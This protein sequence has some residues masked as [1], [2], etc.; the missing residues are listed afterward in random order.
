MRVLVTGASGFIGK[1]LCWHLQAK[2]VEL[3]AVSRSGEPVAGVE[4]HIAVDLS[5]NSLNAENL[6][7]VD[8]VYHLAGI[9]HQS[10]S[11]VAYQRLNCDAVLTLAKQAEQAG[12]KL[13]VFVSSVRAMGR[14]PAGLA[15]TE[16]QCSEPQDPYGLSKWHAEQALRERFAGSDMAVVILRPALVCAPE[17]GGNLAKLRAAVQRG[18][19]RPPDVGSR[20]V[21]ARSDL[22]ELL[23]RV[24]EQEWSGVNTYIVADR[25]ACSFQEIYD[26]YATAF[27]VGKRKT[28]PLWVWRGF[29]RVVQWVQRQPPG[30]TLYEKLFG[31]DR[32]DSHAICWRLDWHPVTSLEEALVGT[33]DTSR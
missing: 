16:K 22:V 18:L 14:G 3:V 2:G 4:Q 11:D 31:Y 10:A 30:N 15:R 32:Y 8:V 25:R 23:G 19:P 20:S 6:Q 9:A 29:C 21:I 33:T 28:L 13:F 27:G 24:A 7:G 17:A 26:F 1:P 5:Q 12:V